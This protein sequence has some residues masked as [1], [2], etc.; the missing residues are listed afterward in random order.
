MTESAAGQNSAN[1]ID[2][3]ICKKLKKK[4]KRTIEEIGIEVENAQSDCKSEDSFEPHSKPCKKKRKKDKREKKSKDKSDKESKS[5][6]GGNLE[7]GVYFGSEQND[8]KA[9]KNAHDLNSETKDIVV[10]QDKPE[11]E[12]TVKDL[13]LKKVKKKK[14]KK[15]NTV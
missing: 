7:K 5:D 2:E 8:I 10:K 4:K 15:K 9:C 12:E 13:T 6:Y 14:K 11:S 3:N 1:G